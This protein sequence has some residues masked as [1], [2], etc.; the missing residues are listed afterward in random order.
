[1]LCVVEF[2]GWGGVC[3]LN[4]SEVRAYVV[5]KTSL[6]EICIGVAVLYFSFRFSYWWM[7]RL[8]SLSIIL[9]QDIPVIFFCIN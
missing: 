4:F 2:R 8:M 1:M 6:I 7:N 3:D 5:V 9:R